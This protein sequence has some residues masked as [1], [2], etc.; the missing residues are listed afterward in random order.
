MAL[1]P[2]ETQIL[3]SCTRCSPT[4]YEMLKHFYEELPGFESQPGHIQPGHRSELFTVPGAVA[5]RCVFTGL[6]AAFCLA[7]TRTQIKA[8][9]Q[10]L[11]ASELGEITA[12]LQRRAEFTSLENSG[13]LKHLYKWTE[14]PK[15]DFPALPPC[16]SP[17]APMPCESCT[18]L[19]H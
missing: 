5:A 12:A 19:Q 1:L 8:F 13:V 3:C 10:P 2:S 16:T 9:A 11:K 7:P 18:H 4:G 15:C 6:S 14:R 17:S